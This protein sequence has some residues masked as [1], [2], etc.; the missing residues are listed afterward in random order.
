V[1]VTFLSRHQLVTCHD[2]VIRSC[3]QHTISTKFTVSEFSLKTQDVSSESCDVTFETLEYTC[4]DCTKSWARD[5]V[6]DHKFDDAAV[7]VISDTT[8]VIHTV[9]G[10]S[11][12]RSGSQLLGNSLL[13]SYGYHSY[14]LTLSF[15]YGYHSYS[16]AASPLATDIIATLP[17]P[18]F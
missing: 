4:I 18:R 17:L 14:V 16:F 10:S 12:F 6:A 8:T 5:L 7:Y 11:R 3:C 1:S 9:I 2:V 13:F 15:S